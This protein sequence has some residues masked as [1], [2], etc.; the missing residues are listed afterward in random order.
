MGYVVLYKYNTMKHHYYTTQGPHDHFYN[1]VEV[2]YPPFW[3]AH[4]LFVIWTFFIIGLLFYLW[5][6]DKGDHVK[7]IL[8]FVISIAFIL[9][10][11]KTWDYTYLL[12]ML[13]IIFVLISPIIYKFF[14][15]LPSIIYKMSKETLAQAISAIYFNKRKLIEIGEIVEQAEEII[16]DAFSLENEVANMKKHYEEWNVSEFKKSFSRLKMQIPN[17]EVEKKEA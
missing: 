7:Y 15:F 5:Y 13:F 16:K 1:E 8:G 17:K 12:A 4:P 14:V 3:S 11:T 10:F 9:W 2:N 6:K